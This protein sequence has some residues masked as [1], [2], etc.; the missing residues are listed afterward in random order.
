MDVEEIAHRIV[1]ARGHQYGAHLRMRRTVL[2]GA[3]RPQNVERRGERIG[4]GGRG[5][6][7]GRRK[8]CPSSSKNCVPAPE[9]PRA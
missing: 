3:G 8:R 9:V 5:R 7:R 1:V 6:N 2:R 4:L